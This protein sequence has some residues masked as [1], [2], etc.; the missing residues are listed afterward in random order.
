MLRRFPGGLLVVL[1]LRGR[2][3]QPP[4]RMTSP[5]ALQASKYVLGKASSGGSASIAS[6]PVEYPAEVSQAGIRSIAVAA[7]GRTKFV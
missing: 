4:I 5:A 2:L 7:S 3:V 6:C 1:D